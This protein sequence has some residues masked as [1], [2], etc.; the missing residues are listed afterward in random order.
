MLSEEKK[1]KKIKTN[2]PENMVQ[3]QVLRGCEGRRHLKTADL[4]L[5]GPLGEILSISK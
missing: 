2:N 1:P 3:S 5:S 4:G